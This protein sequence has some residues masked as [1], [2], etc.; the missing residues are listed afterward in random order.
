ME[1]YFYFGEDDVATTAEACMFPLSSF[2][3]MSPSGAAAT[4][5][6][7]KARNGT[8]T[9]DIVGFDHTG[10]GFKAFATELVKFL[11]ANQKNPF[12]I[13]HDGESNTSILGS[14]IVNVTISSSN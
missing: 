9:D 1:R 7:F 6:F 11:K 13:V 10:T 4:R 5:A 2:L 8:L 14:T 12:L 3:G